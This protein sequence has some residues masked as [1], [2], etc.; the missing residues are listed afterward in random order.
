MET[1]HRASQAPPSLPPVLLD[2]IDA[3]EGNS[4]ASSDARL[5]HDLKLLEDGHDLPWGAFANAVIEVADNANHHSSG[6]WVAAVSVDQAKDHAAFCVRDFGLGFQGSVQAGSNDMAKALVPLRAS[7]PL[8]AILPGQSCGRDSG[9]SM[10]LQ[11]HHGGSGLFSFTELLRQ[12]GGSG[13]LR[14]GQSQLIFLNGTIF[15]TGIQP[16]THGVLVA[17][18]STYKQAFNPTLLK[19]KWISTIATVTHTAAENFFERCPQCPTP[20][21]A[22][23]PVFHRSLAKCFQ[24]VKEKV[25]QW[26]QFVLYA[27]AYG[28]T[29]LR[30][31]LAPTF[32]VDLLMASLLSRSLVVVASEVS[33]SVANSLLS[34][35]CRVIESLDELSTSMASSSPA[36]TATT[37]TTSSTI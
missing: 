26:P 32:H 12:S 11:A 21:D 30:R 20:Q 6:S 25:P 8:W 17:F 4:H 18:A 3:V 22:E 27:S 16:E 14:C 2:I 23:F 36:S 1:S 31:A 15:L 37:S 5:F 7:L 35:N 34:V 13:I 19:Q 33:A 29:A 9:L 10:D 24:C 28:G